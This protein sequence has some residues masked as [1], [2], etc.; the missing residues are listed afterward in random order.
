MIRVLRFD[1][2]RVMPWKNG[3]GTTAQIAIHPEGATFPGDDFLWRVSSAKVTESGPF[4]VFPGC[5]RILAVWQGTGMML[6]G[7][8]LMPL[9]PLKFMGEDAQQAELV[10]GPVLD[11]GVIY[12]RDRVTAEMK[13]EN[14]LPGAERLSLAL[15]E[16]T[17]LL[18]CAEGSFDV[19]GI[20]ASSGDT[21]RLDGPALVNLRGHGSVPTRIFRISL[22]LKALA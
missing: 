15:G 9:V 4:S 14:I 17:H 19:E 5:D 16:G 21:M 11:L 6:N 12:R 18:V 7:Q 3:R 1:N 22:A 8:L 20:R 10:G 2:Y 13:L